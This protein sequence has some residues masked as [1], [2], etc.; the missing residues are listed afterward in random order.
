MKAVTYKEIEMYWMGK[1]EDGDIIAQ[2]LLYR[3]IQF[4][5]NQ[6]KL[7]TEVNKAGVMD[8]VKNSHQ[9]YTNPNKMLKEI[10]DIEKELQKIET[11][12]QKYVRSN[13]PDDTNEKRAPLI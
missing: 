6:R 1:F 3:Y 10:R 4:T 2:N 13:T 11:A 8:E 5:K 9:Q 7:Q 12:L